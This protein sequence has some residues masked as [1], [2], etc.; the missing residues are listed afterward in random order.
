[1]AGK[2]L[3][4]QEFDDELEVG[5]FKEDA[6]PEP[7]EILKDPPLKG[8]D[9]EI[10]VSDDTPEADRGKWNADN[11]PT[12]EDENL[13]EAEKH[14]R[15]V[16]K[17]IDKETAKTHA[18]RRAKEDRERQLVEA[19]AAMKRLI[20]EN[21][22]LKSMIEDG[23][24]V[25]VS[26]HQGRL[27]AQLAQAK[28]AYKEAHDAGD[29]EGMIA[30][31][32]QM[33]R[34]VAQLDRLSTHRVNS[35]PRME[36]TEAERIIP[37]PLPRSQQPAEPEVEA[38]KEKNPWFMRDE[39]MTNLALAKHRQLVAAG[40]QINSDEYFGSIDAEVRK[41]FPEKFQNE[42]RGGGR[43]AAPMVSQPSRSGGE[44]GP[45]TRVTLTSS[46][47]TL[48]RRLGLTEKQYAEQLVA[49]NGSKEW[50]YGRKS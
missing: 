21:S 37:Q 4:D 43:R 26:E 46:Q 47:V 49:E 24:K 13:T 45:R 7:S 20:Q 27:E 35:L 29:P 44:G 41:R 18:E 36:E 11:L 23:E 17:R 6:L 40:V 12:D 33:S 15:K 10:V 2:S 8:E 34:T 22:Q 19:T 3:I 5:T 25:L 9:I 42:N 39:M 38:W 28:R 48:A 31:Q 30:A 32:E 1:M 14:S 16:Q 50:T